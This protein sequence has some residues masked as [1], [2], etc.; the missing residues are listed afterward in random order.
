VSPF[1]NIYCL[2]GVFGLSVILH[3]TVTFTSR[4]K[5]DV[6]IAGKPHQPRVIFSTSYNLLPTTK[7]STMVRTPALW[8]GETIYRELSCF[9]FVSDFFSFGWGYF[10][11]WILVERGRI[12]LLLFFL[13][14]FCGMLRSCGSS[15]GY[16]YY[17][18]AINICWFLPE[19][20]LREILDGA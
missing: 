2:A 19:K 5:R 3:S 18:A 6:A 20:F 4:A 12:S 9:A 10:H 16:Q 13:L 1:K 7:T 11:L 17:G 8:R 15:C 14:S